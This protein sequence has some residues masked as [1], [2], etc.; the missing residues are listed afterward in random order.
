M[1][2]HRPEAAADILI[3]GG[4]LL[5]VHPGLPAVLH[6]GYLAI[7]DGRIM[8]LGPMADCPPAL[9]KAAGRILDARDRLV[10][11]GLVNAHCHAAMTLFRG[12]ADDLPLATWLFEK[13]FPAEARFM[14]PEAVAAASRLAAAEMLLAGTTTV[15][16]AYFHED[17]AAGALADLGLRVVA[18]QGVIDFPA[19]GVPDPRENVARARDFLGRWQG[20]HARVQPAL[21]C[22]APYTCSAA[23]LVAAKEAASAAGAL[24]L[25]HVAETRAEVERWQAEHGMSPLQ[26]LARLGVLDRGS[27]LV[28]GVWLD[29][30]D[31]EVLAASGAG[32]VL[33]P[34]SNLKLACGISPLPALLAAGVPVALGTDGAASN[35]RLD[36]FSELAC[37]RALHRRAVPAPALLA[38]ATAGGAAVLGLGRWLGALAPGY[39][40]DVVIIEAPQPTAG[41]EEAVC[42]RRGADVRT[43]LVGGRVVVEERQLLTG[44]LAGIAGQVREL[45]RRVQPA[46]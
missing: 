37:C 38:M 18:A 41:E 1:D 10:V 29:D 25:T 4:C 27:V 21:F 6:P 2:S 12:L 16:D 13:I 46:P 30:A 14:D 24:W 32:L 3:T 20:R 26:S 34:R 36:L 8:S 33:C 11:P 17:A 23:T 39:A 44:D 15:A 22:H 45:A 35:N 19:P 9:A 40:A 5:P 43:V 7:T 42:R 28:H 31:I